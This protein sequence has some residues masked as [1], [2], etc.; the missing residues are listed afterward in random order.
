MR[1]THGGTASAIDWSSLFR[2][3]MLNENWRK[4]K[5]V[6]HLNVLDMINQSLVL[7]HLFTISYGIIWY[8]IK[9]NFHLFIGTPLNSLKIYY[10][11]VHIIIDRATIEYLL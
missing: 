11:H 7:F 5:H 2:G 9:I 3:F 10:H 8:S 1:G 4:Q 6:F